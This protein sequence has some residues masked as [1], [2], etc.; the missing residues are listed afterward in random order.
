MNHRLLFFAVVAL[1]ALAA[2]AGFHPY[3]GRCQTAT[4]PAVALSLSMPQEYLNYTITS[5]NGAMWATIDG[6]Y[7]IHLTGNFINLPMVYPTPPNTTNIHITWDGSELAWGNYSDIDPSARHHTEIG[8]WQMVYCTVRPAQADFLLQIHYQHPLQIING[9]FTFL[10]DLNIADYLSSQ[11]P[12]STAHFTIKLPANSSGMNVYTTGTTGDTWSQVA[13]NMTESTTAKTA[14]F[15]IVSEYGKP[16]NGDI[17]FILQD[18]PVPEFPLW[19]LPLLLAAATLVIAVFLAKL[20][21]ESSGL[22]GFTKAK[23][24]SRSA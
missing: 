19:I 4:P 11:T 21:R 20:V 8:D 15:D 12:N 16:L 6:I 17:A 18:S 9:S 24:I 7:P 2:I 10:Y 13:C 14:T 1:L 23:N 5:V 3:F 22:V